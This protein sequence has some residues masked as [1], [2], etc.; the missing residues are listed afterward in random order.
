MYR[1]IRPP[2]PCLTPTTSIAFVIT[3][4]FPDLVP[5]VAIFEM[6]HVKRWEILDETLLNFC[7]TI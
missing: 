2:Q 4:Q 6:F 7:K 3:F 1:P 5:Y